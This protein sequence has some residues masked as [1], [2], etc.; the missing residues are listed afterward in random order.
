MNQVTLVGRVSTEPELRYTQAGIAHLKFNVAVEDGKDQAGNKKTQFIRV[1]AWRKAAEVHAT[2]M[3]KGLLIS[4][5]GGLESRNYEKKVGD[6]TF[7][8]N[9]THVVAEDIRYLETKSQV[10]ERNR[11]KNDPVY[12]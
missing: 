9:D 1:H 2:H 11:R 5:V 4:V 8:A 3:T 6:Q 10:D 12:S 7:M